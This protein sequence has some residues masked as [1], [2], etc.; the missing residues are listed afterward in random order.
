MG[1]NNNTIASTIA[2]LH[3]YGPNTMGCNV[4]QNEHSQLACTICA[5]S[6]YS[7]SNM[8]V[9]YVYSQYVYAQHA[10]SQYIH[11]QDVHVPCR[12]TDL[13]SM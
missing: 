10:Y 7:V 2:R 1:C 4:C 11:S 8:H 12:Y 5:T 9:Q 3:L 13:Y 6:I